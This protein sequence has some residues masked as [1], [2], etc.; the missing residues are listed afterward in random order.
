MKITCL[1]DNCALE[2]FAHEHGLSYYI[3]ACGRRFLFDMG[4]SESYISNAVALGIDLAAADFA[5]LSHGHYDHGGGLA[6]FVRLNPTA[7]VYLREGAFERRYSHKP[8]HELEY[9]GLDEGLRGSRRL[10][11]TGELYSIAPGLTLFAGVYGSELRSG[12]NDVLL[13]P[14]AKTPDS[15]A[16]EQNLLIVE[17]GRHVLICGC[18]HRG[19][20]NIINRLSNIDPTHPAAVFGGFHLA[21]PGSGVVDVTLCDATADELLK[22]PDT[23]CYTGH[24][25]GTESYERLRARMG[26]RVRYLHA[27]ESVVIE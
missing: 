11:E 4:A 13:G 5:V 25:T 16:H 24:C 6:A 2:G 21:I 1:V 17:N 22:L 15:F 14:D 10:V 12:A 3:E 9:I 26:D 19:V 27:G 18:A 20:I 23:I 8:G 7:P